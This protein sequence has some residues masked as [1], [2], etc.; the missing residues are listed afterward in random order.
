MSKVANLT[1]EQIERYYLTPSVVDKI[2][3]YLEGKNVAVR[4]G[5]DDGSSAILRK[6]KEGTPHKITSRADYEYW[7]KRRAQE[8]LP[9]YGKK[10]DHLLV[11]IDPGSKVPFTDV[12]SITQKVR[13]AASNYGKPEVTYTGGR[14]FHVRAYLDKP[15][16]I[17]KARKLS[18]ELASRVGSTGPRTSEKDI[19]LDITPLKY[20]GVVRTPYTV[21]KKTGRVA[22]PV[23]NLSTFEPEEATMPKTSSILEWMEK[24][25]SDEWADALSQKLAWDKWEATMLSPQEI[26]KLGNATDL[27]P[28]G[29]SAGMPD[30]AFNQEQLQMGEKV[31]RNEHVKGGKLPKQVSD[32]L[33]R[34]IAKDHLQEFPDYYTHLKEM[35]AKA[36]KK[37]CSTLVD[38][39]HWLKGK[40]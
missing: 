39:F 20:R 30:S 15:I 25:A 24:D 5:L 14:G 27:I 17:G 8:I 4:I 38:T 37:A 13:D 36:E 11:D 26:Q 22:T 28:G 29:M 18:Q 32:H 12:K 1:R 2:Y 10:V 9:E 16:D 19:R 40:R 21:N 31:E 7:V 34:E 6:N 33:A 3:P 35:E 23:D